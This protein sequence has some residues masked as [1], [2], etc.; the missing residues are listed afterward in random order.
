M[1]LLYKS[2]NIFLIKCRH[3]ADLIENTFSDL[4]EI[5]DLTISAAL[6]STTIFETLKL[7][8]NILIY[9]HVK[10]KTPWD[11]YDEIYYKEGELNKKLRFLLK[12]TDLEKLNLLSKISSDFNL[13]FD[14]IELI[15]KD[16]NKQLI[17]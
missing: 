12:L 5:T 14:S 11:K 16:I 6:N 9:N 8:K 7:N 3:P 4:L 17:N 15:L 1:D 10:F 2:K 13:N